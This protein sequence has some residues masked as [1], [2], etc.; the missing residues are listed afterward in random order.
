[1]SVVPGEVMSEAWTRWQGHLIHD[2][3]PLGRFLGGSDRSGVFMTRS[4]A[5]DSPEMAI[6]LVPTDR[7][8]AE[9]QLPRWNRAI[10]I[11]HPQLL[12]LLRSGGCQLDGLPYLYVVMEYA[13]QTLSQLLQSR[14]LTDEE[15]RDMLRPILD[16]LVFLH[17]LNLVHG[18]LKPENILVV[19]DQLKLASDT[20]RRV[21]EGPVSA[22]ALTVYD[23]PEARLGS[24]S[25]AGDIWALGICLFEALTRGRSSGPGARSAVDALP[26]DFSPAFREIVARC[27]SPN[28]Q[29][30][31][32]ATELLAW[33]SGKPTGSAPKAAI[34]VTPEP[35]PSMAKSLHPRALINAVL[36]GVVVLALGWAGVRMLG[37]QGNPTTLPGAQGSPSQTTGASAPLSAAARQS[38]PTRSDLAASLPAL[39]EVLPAASQSARRTIV[40]HI[41]VW[42][43]VIVDPDGTVYAATAD[44]AGPSRYFQRLAIEAAKQWTFPPIDSQSRRLMQIRFDFSR[45]GTAGRAVTLH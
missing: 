39:H 22:R 12:G 9:T 41:K 15:A 2:E 42:I 14:A 26:A 33:I 30:R 24:S 11:V 4:A 6:K 16:A 38:K 45:D 21:T 23:P 37:S 1:M 18:Q 34:Q 3:F 29:D 36:G 32:S 35:A 19:G 44:R 31:S 13:D 7:A 27:L 8:L 40:G 28:P 25:A 17:S 5:P 10:G 43:R 20:I